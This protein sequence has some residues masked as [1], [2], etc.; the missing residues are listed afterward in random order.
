MCKSC[1]VL[2]SSKPSSINLICLLTAYWLP[3]TILINLLDAS[4][5]W[6]VNTLYALTRVGYLLAS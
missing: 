2:A 4:R 1:L 5:D 6:R 3:Y